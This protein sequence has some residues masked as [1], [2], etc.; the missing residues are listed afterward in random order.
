MEIT[1][2]NIQKLQT[3]F[4][5]LYNQGKASVQS[6]YKTVAMEVPSSTRSNNYGWMNEL[7]KMREWLGARVVNNISAQTFEIVNKPFELTIGV[8]RANIEDD[9]LGVYSMRFIAMGESV[10]QQPDE[11]VWDMFKRGT[12]TLCYDGQ[13]FFDSDHPVQLE[14]GTMGTVS[15]F[16]AGAGPYTWYLIDESN[17]YR[18]IVFQNRKSPQFVSKDKPED[19]NVFERNEFIYGVD[20]RRNAGFGFWQKAFA[21]TLPLTVDNFYTV[22]QAM[23]GLKGDYGRPLR[24]RP[25]KLLVPPG[26]MKDAKTVLETDLRA[27][28]GVAIT[29]IAKGLVTPMMEPLLA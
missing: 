26:G 7:P 27:D 23:A 15:N 2:A 22:Y 4:R 28:A 14:N 21:S 1:P 9:D 25:T 17:S 6:T 19:D 13:F 12:S 24:L 16:Y 5:A 3:S 20:A 18:P 29:N 11:L 8:N 10:E